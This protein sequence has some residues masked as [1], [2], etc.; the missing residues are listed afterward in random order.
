MNQQK[1]K[2][3]LALLLSV[4][5][6]FSMS[7]VNVFA[8][9]SG[10]PIGASS[11]VDSS[12]PAVCEN[13]KEH[14]E[15]CGYA[16]AVDGTPCGHLNEDGS[17]SCAPI[18]D[19]D[20]SD[21]NA[22]PSDADMEYVCDHTDGC[23]YTEA[24]E[25]ADCAHECEL[26]NPDKGD[27][28][29]QCS[30]KALCT[31]SQI[32]PD[33]PVCTAEG[34]DLDEMCKGKA[35]PAP[36]CDCTVQCTAADADN[37]V[38]AAINADCPVCGAENA[39]LAECKG[40]AAMLLDVMPLAAET[41]NGTKI[42]TALDFRTNDDN[43][44]PTDC[45]DAGIGHTHS[46]EADKCF[47]WADNTLTLNNLNLDTSATVT[48]PIALTLPADA[49]V[50]MNG[51]S[52]V[53]SK[54]NGS[55]DA[56]GIYGGDLNFSGSGSLTAT[57]G[58]SNNISYGVCAYSN[59]AVS[60]GTLTATGGQANNNSYGVVAIN[61]TVSGT[62]TLTATGG[63]ATSTSGGSIGSVGA[64]AR[65]GV[66]TVSSGTFEAKTT[67]TDGTAQAVNKVPTADKGATL[68]IT[69]SETVGGALS[70]VSDLSNSN[71]GTYKHL[72]V[73]A[74]P[75]PAD[76]PNGEKIT[77]A[78]D[79]TTT[80]GNTPPT[81]CTATGI[82]HTHTSTEKCF[83][84]ANNTLTLNN[85]NLETSATVTAPI[86]LTLPADATVE[87]NGT[88]TVTSKYNGSS[89]TYGIY[90]GALNFSGS[91]SLTAN[92]GTATNDSSYGVC[93]YKNLTISGGTL[94]ANGGQANNNSC[95][96]VASNIT[97]SGTGTLTTTG[98][99]ATNSHGVFTTSNITVESGTF[100][101]KSTS[102]TGTTVQAVN[103]APITTGYTNVKIT[104][105]TTVDGTLGAYD[106]NQITIYKHIK[107]EQGTATSDVAEI[108]T[109]G[110]PTLAD[111]VAAV[112]SGDTIKLLASITGTMTIPSSNT[113]NFTLDL[114]GKTLNGGDDT[115]A[116][117]HNG[118]GTLI[119]KDSASGGK[120]TS[121]AVNYQ[122]NTISLLSGSAGQE[123]L[124]IIG[125]TVESTG[126]GSAI[127]NRAKGTVNVSGGTVNGGSA[128]ILNTDTGAIN[129]SGGKVNGNTGNAI[130]NQNAGPITISGTAIVTSENT[131]TDSGTIELYGETAG[132]E[133]L[134]IEGGTVMNTAYPEGGDDSKDGIA[135]FNKGS[136][137]IAIKG[138]EVTSRCITDDKGTIF[139]TAGSLELSGGEVVGNGSSS[140]PSTAIYTTG[141]GTVTM[142]S[143]TYTIQGNGKAMN[144]APIV[145]SG[146]TLT[147]STNISGTP[148]VTYNA[149]DITTYKYIKATAEAS[150]KITQTLDFT[151]SGAKPA[152][153]HASPINHNHGGDK[154]FTWNDTT[155]TLTLNNIEIDVNGGSD[156]YGI[157][158]PGDQNN[159]GAMISTVNWNGVNTIKVT[160]NFISATGIGSPHGSVILAG[161]DDS[162]SLTITT[163]KWYALNAPNG[164]ITINGGILTSTGETG[165]IAGQKGVTVN[166][167]TVNGIATSSRWYGI[168]N[169]VTINGGTV[170]AQTGSGKT[171][172]STE[173]VGTNVTHDN[174]TAAWDNN[175][176]AACTYSATPVSN[177]SFSGLTAN[178][179]SGTTTTT[180]LTLTFDKD[181]AGL[182]AGDIS[183]TG[184]TAGTLTKT[185]TGV[186]KLA[187]SGITVA[188][189]QNVTVAMAKTGFAF[190]PTNKTVEVYKAAAGQTDAEKVAAAKTA[191][192]TAL[193]NFAANNATTAAEILTAVNNAL[194]GTGVTAA[195][196]TPEDFSKQNATTGAAGSITGT[197]KLTCGA[198][199]SDTVSVSLTIAKLAPTG[200]YTITFNA[201]GGS[202]TPTS[203]TTGAD[204]KLTG[205]PTPT[206]SGSYRF[207]GWYT[208]ASG[209]TQV[210][211][212]TIFNQNSTIYAHWTYTGGGSG[213]SGGGSSSGGGN[214]N[215]DSNITVTTPPADKPNI[216]TQG[217]IKVDAKVDTNGNA[218]I[219]ITNQNVTDAFDKALADA[220]K[221]G[222]E[223]N[224]ITLV[225]NVNTGNKTVNSATVNL[226]K[227]AQETIISKQIVNT[228]VVIDSPDIKIGMDL[229]AVKEI[230]KQANADVNITA[231]RGNSASLTGNA[232]TAIGSRPVFDLAVNYGGS[233]AVSN[234]GAGSVSVSIPYTLQ[235]GEKA[236]N[237]QAVYVDA[238]G[239][240]QWLTSSVY[241]S[242]NKVL[243]FNTSHF[244]TYGVGYKQDAPTFTDIANHWA[245]DD[246]QFVVNRGLFAGSSATTFS[247][248]TAMTR[249]MFV[250]A[251]GRLANAD[252]S[253]YKKS[254]FP[255]VKADAYYMGYIEWASKN[256][257]VSGG[258]DGNFHPDASITREQMAVIMS[259]YAKTIGFTTPKVHAENTFSDSAK[260]SSY[261]KTAVKQMQ[262]AGVLAG[263]NGNV[264]DPQGTA[265]R[266]EVSAVLR[267]FVELAISS[268]T[269]QGWTMNDSGQWM[270]YENGKAV[271]GKKDIGG[272]SYTFDQYGMTADVP[273]NQ[274]YTTYVV[275]KNESFGLI[276]QKLGCSVSELERLNNK[277]RFEVIYPGEV[278]R[279]P[280]K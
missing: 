252:V 43:T 130:F 218:A 265:T 3:G 71:V 157:K 44:P 191:A 267:R 194:S 219:N 139:L 116:I 266:A 225:L 94:T 121:N 229:N 135:I 87:M 178:G 39:D 36:E 92:G 235:E 228:V 201:N 277:T 66:I 56:Y 1:I 250:T 40:E 144:K 270:Y 25:G 271:T 203:A 170:T 118:T 198:T 37:G 174:T 176:G 189:G 165:G 18:L 190:N 64:R 79:F 26:C 8:T 72:K 55:S 13:H 38:E 279:V 256:G 249:G 236:G 126:Q 259:N 27:L 205:L 98:G 83:T 227:T 158:L 132:N 93:A 151:D 52:T 214:S 134:K 147:S 161:A 125:G 272:A 17:Y 127:S 10:V 171:P 243:R 185:G 238:N 11:I 145:D 131:S 184:A 180:E 102:N 263:K 88:S 248:N 251:L 117:A 169:D 73:V 62:G 19:S 153:C 148:T 231:I 47:T 112:K 247:P 204:G 242:V 108:G 34:A 67:D 212:A 41:P 31:E 160:T 268:D 264:F 136:G 15:D 221:N 109:T 195:W 9:E 81:D 260:I 156:I 23:G 211:A 49:T 5:M 224:G 46:D 183:L 91:G 206:R 75:A 77:T 239:N 74:T 193:N 89:N 105:S 54:Y 22:T 244:S 96:V 86:A 168:W 68:A 33:C 7:T 138:G 155:K 146:V 202:V 253:G 261:A 154:C 12:T 104:A 207:D 150:K 107:I 188:D 111:A 210:T 276:A 42:T 30:C 101:A 60:G 255:D 275:Q 120:V 114:N 208:A 232:K 21:D 254:S 6:V 199:A 241:D 278:L 181:I 80:D 99:T 142:K 129:I 50:E 215:S 133:V 123:T 200:T 69:G 258:T 48:E 100:E 164:S 246:I 78:L 32:N 128:A 124:A 115:T 95:G 159:P 35:A 233:K 179:T 209:G 85:L 186:Y 182:A 245:K 57:G 234:F 220:K 162:A 237:V 24:E 106:A 257:I 197:I 230:N 141:T 173:P 29:E 137:K 149:A 70:T 262:M 240:V 280:E 20:V 63:T 76:T 2:R 222:N 90:G 119:I 175:I 213:G 65:G 172:F 166:G 163:N 217:E 274:K 61:I 110:Y 58:Q 53:T 143:G 187:I 223:S 113:H 16:E 192:Q 51:T 269:M 4:A 226:P 196:N 97:V 167:G 45:T 84:W 14:D 216:P 82:G 28:Q 122:T 273:K 140:G 103:K 59:L 152:D 177:V